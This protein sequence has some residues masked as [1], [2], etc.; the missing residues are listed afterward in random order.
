[1]KKK[2]AVL[3]AVMLMGALLAGCGNASSGKNTEAAGDGGTKNEKKITMSVACLTGGNNEAYA[4]L[5]ETEIEEFNKTNQY[6]VEL[7]QEA[8]SNEQYKT[9]ITTLMASNAQPDIFFTFE[10]GFLQPFVEGGKI[11]PIGDAI[12]ADEEWSSKYDDKS[13]FGPVTFDGKIY[14]V[15]NTRQVVVVTYNKKMFDEIGVEAPKTYDEFLTVCEA[16]KN[17]GK[18]ALIVP[19]QEAWYAGQL[20]Q[21]IANGIGGA[22]LFEE[23]SAGETDWKDERYVQAGESLTELVQKG[24]LPEGFLGMTPNEGFEKF[25]SG[26]AGMMMNLTSA[27]TM[28]NNQDNPLYD[29]IDFFVLPA[30][31]EQAR[32]VNV[33]STGQMYA[34]S[35]KAEHVEAACAFIKQLSETRYQQELVN[36]G[37]VLVTNVEVN[38]DNVDPMALRMQK[39]FPEVKTYTPWFDRIFATG[40]GTEFNNIAVAIM[41]GGSPEEQF[42]NL[43]Q[44]A[45]DNAER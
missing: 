2:M 35:S 5:I 21:Q 23:T 8:Y 33:G 20:L 12:E 7:V 38:R 6:N 37:Q 45:D 30:K 36:L 1:M 40:E 24:Y 16:L 10:A 9:K 19:C 44:F 26:E 4:K 28:F 31:E 11:Y 14:A 41:A 34:V 25:N 3:A 39:V 42:A 17:N 18:T 32:G 27:I 43:Q 15:P 22:E 13:V 29:D